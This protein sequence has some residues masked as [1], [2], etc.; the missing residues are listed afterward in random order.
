MA[1]L[2]DVL[3]DKNR[4]DDQK[5]TVEGVESTLGE[6]R[7]G[8]MLNSDYTRKTQSLARERQQFE[9]QQGEWE[10]AR[11]EAEAKL[12]EYAKRLVQQNPGSTREEIQDRLDDDPR[13]AKLAAQIDKLN[14]NIEL[15][16]QAQAR[17]QLEMQQ[18]RLASYADQH[19][20]AL[21]YLKSQD[22]DLDS[23]QLVDFAK[24]Q[25]IPNLVTA[26]KAFKYD[27]SV[28]SSVARGKEE[29]IKEGLERAKRE[30]NQPI[31]P[32]RRMVSPAAGADSPKNFD[33]AID[34]AL[35]DP[36]IMATFE[37]GTRI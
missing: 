33:E 18:Q 36:E 19:R 11:L 23:D 14:S 29:G 4:S 31:I 15:I 22:K 1:T 26:Y 3:N 34:K 2:Y 32:S 17:Q 8:V 20:R 25:G 27:D 35:A 21:A 30:L 5:I 37:G 10:Y 13:A 9:Q 6:L 28:K 12:G 16:G 7:K 24:S